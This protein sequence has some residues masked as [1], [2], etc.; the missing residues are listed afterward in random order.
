MGEA[1]RFS[2]GNGD[3]AEAP[4]TAE[5]FEVVGENVRAP[6]GNGQFEDHI[7]VGILQA[8]SPEV[9]DVLPVTLPGEIPEKG[10]R[11]F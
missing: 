5:V 6:G 8:R 4:G 9:E 10:E 3:D 11:L 1:V 2:G 7:I